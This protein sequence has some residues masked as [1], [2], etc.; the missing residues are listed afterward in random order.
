MKFLTNSNKVVSGEEV[1]IEDEMN[2]RGKNV[3]VIGGGDTGSDCVGTSIRQGAKSVTQIELL[4]KPTDER[5]EQNPWPEWPMI[6]STSTSQKEGCERNWSLLTKEF[7]GNEKDELMG[8][9]V[10]DVEWIDQ[11]KFKFKE[12]NGTEKVIPCERAFLAIGFLGPQKEGLL[13]QLGIET[14]ER[15]NI[16]DN[17]YQTNKPNI[18][19]AGDCRRGQSLVVWAI[20]EG[21]KAAYS[22]NKFLS[23]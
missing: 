21:R 13:E 4:G 17:M 11:S 1:M 18:F 9:K 12:I 14:D 16:I 3:V 7:I 6:L 23:N 20:S 19:T 10:V 2:A 15:S 5:T 22:V 8:I